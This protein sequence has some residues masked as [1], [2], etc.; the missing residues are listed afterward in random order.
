MGR[1]SSSLRRLLKAK[2][3][4]TIKQHRCFS[5]FINECYGIEGDVYPSDVLISWHWHNIDA[6]G[7]RLSCDDLS[8]VGIYISSPIGGERSM[9]ILFSELSNE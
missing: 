9:T 6:N 2:N 1:I 7:Q 5:K 8:A 4:L 3:D